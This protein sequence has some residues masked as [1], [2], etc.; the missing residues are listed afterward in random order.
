MILRL[1]I[2]LLFFLF[3]ANTRDV[4]YAQQ[5]LSNNLRD[6][7]YQSGKDRLQVD[8]PEYNALEQLGYPIGEGIVITPSLNAISGYDSNIDN[9]F[10]EQESAYSVLDASMV[11][12]FVRPNAATT[13]ALKGSIGEYAEVDRSE[14]WDAGVTLDSYYALESGIELSGGA[15]YLRDSLSFTENQSFAGYGQAEYKN[16]NIE[17]YIRSIGYQVEYLSQPAISFLLSAPLSTLSLNSEFN[18][19]RADQTAGI[20]VGRNRMLGA[21]VEGGYS[22]IDYIN[23]KASNTVDRDA[24]EYWGTVGSRITIGS[25]LRAD[26]GYRFNYRNLDDTVIKDYDTS[27]L[28]AKLTWLP[29]SNFKAVVEVDRKLGNPSTALSRVANS[30]T[31]GITLAYKPTANF[32]YALKAYQKR[33]KQIGDNISYLERWLQSETTYDL[34]NKSQLYL[35][36]TIGHVKD[37]V[38]QA[39]YDRYGVG[40]GYRKQFNATKSTP[41]GSLLSDLKDLP[42]ENKLV[43]V[44][45]GYSHLI[46]PEMRMTT[47]TDPFL[48]ESIQHIKDHEGE[49]RGYKLHFDVGDVS[50]ENEYGIEQTD[51]ALKGFYGNYDITDYSECGF[52]INFDCV[53]IN[54]VDVNPADDNNT[55]PF[56]ALVTR[57]KRNVHHWGIAA[58]APLWDNEVEL[59]LKGGPPVTKPS[60]IK[61]GVALKAIQQR[62]N[63]FAIDVSV[64]DPVDYDEDL[65]TFYYGAYLGYQREFL[66]RHNLSLKLNAEAG[67]YY[68]DTDY[69]GQYLAYLPVGGMNILQILAR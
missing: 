59:N 11:L 60:Y 58:E 15:Y 45:P 23:Q 57:T 18:L 39:S 52:T 9:L 25:K 24:D 16:Q 1:T 63:L 36:S 7:T 64:P 17:A 30:T 33:D 66:L 65:D 68:A 48:T 21:Y 14:R 5:P 50:G 31:F 8:K 62:T 6:K 61:F 10:A 22:V 12:G 37:E 41:W 20:L 13:L 55:G 54:I 53:F 47:V 67:L 44:R 2:C 34:N 51:F 69:Q 49:M 3:V 35:K 19:R 29:V 42:I 56:G 26:I 38:S 32:T 4:L 43:S 46:L 28:D 40:F 27:F